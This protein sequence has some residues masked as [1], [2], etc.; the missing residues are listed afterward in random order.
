MCFI[1]SCDTIK[2]YNITTHFI[3]KNLTLE[4]VNIILSDVNNVT[5]NNYLVEPNKEIKISLT[6]EGGKNGL[7]QPFAFGNSTDKIATKIIVK[8]NT[9]NK[10]LTFLEG[11]GM[12]N[13]K[14]YDNFTE[15]MYNTSNNTLIYNIDNEEL[16]LATTCP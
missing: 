11:E 15:S 14:S 7:G 12:L 8:F 13:I 3:Y 4:N 5:F 6:Q 10:C 2:E 1:S 9:S 16:D